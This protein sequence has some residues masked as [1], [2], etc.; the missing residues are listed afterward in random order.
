MDD[1]NYQ[2]L[3]KSGLNF[4]NI[5]DLVLLWSDSNKATLSKLIHYYAKTD[6]LFKLKSG[7]YSLIPLDKITQE[8]L[9]IIAQKII[10]PSYIS[11]HTALTKYALN[12]QYYK[13]IHL[14]SLYNK[15]IQISIG[16]LG[17]IEF[18]FHKLQSDLFFDSTG[19]E[20]TKTDFGTYSIVSPERAIIESWYLNKQIGID[21]ARIKLNTKLLI[22]LATIF[23]QSRINRNLK[24]VFNITV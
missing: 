8:H 24:N 14:C 23:D 15:T 19:I 13:S 20:T 18:V 21:N 22:K 5:D 7:L 10:T 2:K 12:F 11:Y 3:L 16:N 17:V 1:N 9:P 4:F 6:R